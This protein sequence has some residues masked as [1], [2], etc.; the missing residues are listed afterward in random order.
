MK[1]NIQNIRLVK[2]IITLDIKLY[3]TKIKSILLK[4]NV[5]RN[6]FQKLNIK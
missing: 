4:N 2:L 3:N 6:F 5:Y 1:I